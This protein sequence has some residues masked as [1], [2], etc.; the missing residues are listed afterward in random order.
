M[1]FFDH[2]ASARVRSR[3]L[4]M[5]FVVAVTVTVL[6]LHLGLWALFKLVGWSTPPHFAA[7]NIGLGLM[8]VLGGWWIESSSLQSGERL[9]RR[10]G[11]RELRPGVS[12]A[13]QRLV[14]TVQEMAL[15]AQM[16]RPLVMVQPR[17]V[18]INAFAAGWT[19]ADW[20]VVV[21]EGALDALTR[22]E[23]QGLVAHEM[24]HLREG[25]TRINMQLAG[26]VAGL[27]MLHG[28]GQ[29]LR[30]LGRGDSP[31]ADRRPVWRALTVPPG[32]VIMG[33]GWLGWMAGRLLQA[34]ISRERELLADARAVQWTRS[35]DGLGGVLRK[36]MTQRRAGVAAV[37]RGWHGVFSHMML[38]DERVQARWLDSHPPLAE[39]V[40]R[41]YGRAM[42]PLPLQA[43]DPRSGEARPEGAAAMTGF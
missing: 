25:D 14:N 17:V 43:I 4:M 35:R 30:D 1:R 21:T 12:F 16:P 3:R 2:Q 42:Q 20:V 18:A 19:P 5:A 22:D 27:E 13:E 6:G 34:A 10:L 15:A 8:M 31:E 41:L 26:M 29:A 39:R 40:A 11:A 36:V 32:V 33:V 7:V 28:Y 37:A 9:A 23:L 38:I 24:S